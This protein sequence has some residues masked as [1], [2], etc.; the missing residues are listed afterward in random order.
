M[1]VSS[2]H[3]ARHI[4]I[5]KGRAC[6]YQVCS[7]LPQ[8]QRD[9]CVAFVEREARQIYEKISGETVP[10]L[11]AELGSCKATEH[12]ANPSNGGDCTLCK[13]GLSTAVKELND[14]TTQSVILNKASVRYRHSCKG[15]AA[16]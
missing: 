5:L 9:G 13:V 14:P 2:V 15:C 6:I 4:V 12:V 16:I 7:I 10:Q 11:C 8:Q 3:D 1:A